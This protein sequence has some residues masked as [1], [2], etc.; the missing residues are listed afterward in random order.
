VRVRSLPLSHR[1]FARLTCGRTIIGRRWQ[2]VARGACLIVPLGVALGASPGVGLASSPYCSSDGSVVDVA[3]EAQFQVSLEQ[4]DAKVGAAGRV[5]AG[6]QQA[7]RTVVAHHNANVVAEQATCPF[8]GDGKPFRPYTQIATAPGGVLAML[9]H[10]APRVGYRLELIPYGDAGPIYAIITPDRCDP[11]PATATGLRAGGGGPPATIPAPAAKGPLATAI[12]NFT[13]KLDAFEQ[14]ALNNA[15]EAQLAIGA[16]LMIDAQQKM[17]LAGYRAMQQGASYDGYFGMFCGAVIRG[18]HKLAQLA[19]RI[20]Q[21]VG[22]LEA[23]RQIARGQAW[24]F[25]NFPQL[26]RVYSAMT[27]AEQNMAEQAIRSWGKN[28]L[29]VLEIWE[30]DAGATR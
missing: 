12:D 27:A 2:W 24:L 17:I 22:D 16:Q 8:D 18:D 28:L 7:F 14:L 23:L 1:L 20:R 6:Q 15:S 29:E 30:R 10:I 26:Q 4:L 13:A 5:S 21:W 11:A 9:E 19:G 25:S 3:A